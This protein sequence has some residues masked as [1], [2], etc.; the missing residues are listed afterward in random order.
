MISST[1]YFQDSDLENFIE[2]LNQFSPRKWVQ[3]NAT[4]KIGAQ[5]LLMMINNG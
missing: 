5:N 2:R 1:R 4:N 3:E